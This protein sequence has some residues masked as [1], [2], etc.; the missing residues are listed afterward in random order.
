MLTERVISTRN[1]TV[2]PEQEC[3]LPGAGRVRLCDFLTFILI[4]TR[5]EMPS[6]VWVTVGA[7]F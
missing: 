2:A 6:S 4:E 7:F 1:E 3:A 5:A